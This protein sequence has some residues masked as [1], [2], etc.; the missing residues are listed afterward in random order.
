[1]LFRS[2]ENPSSDSSL[3]GK[4]GAGSLALQSAH[5]LPGILLI[6][7]DNRLTTLLPCCVGDAGNTIDSLLPINLERD[8]IKAPLPLCPLDSVS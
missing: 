7:H 2:L 6:H 1:V 4:T 5:Y 8:K 3:F